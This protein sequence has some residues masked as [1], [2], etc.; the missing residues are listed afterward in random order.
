MFRGTAPSSEINLVHVTYRTSR[1]KLRAYNNIITHLTASL[2]TLIHALM[3]IFQVTWLYTYFLNL[4]NNLSQMKAII[5]L[6]S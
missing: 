4:I 5:N 1:P 6:F 2:T 3:R